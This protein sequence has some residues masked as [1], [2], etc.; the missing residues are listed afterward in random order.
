MPLKTGQLW[1]SSLRNRKKKEWGKN[2][3]A[4][5]VYMYTNIDITGV[6]GGKVT[7]KGT[8]EIFKDILAENNPKLMKNI[9]IHIQEA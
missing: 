6:P 4:P 5:E 2:E 8:D 1:L 7:E 3:Q 9:Y